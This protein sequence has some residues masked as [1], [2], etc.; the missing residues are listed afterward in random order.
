MKAHFTRR[1]VAGLIVVIPIGAVL[2]AVY[3]LLELLE[4]LG[5]P[6][7]GLIG[8]GTWVDAFAEQILIILS[9]VFVIYLLGYLADRPMFRKRVESLDRFLVSMIPGYS[10]IKAIIG[11]V[12]K[13]ESLVEELR[14]VL[15]QVQ[16]GDRIGFEIER[17]GSGQVVIYLPNTPT[18]VSGITL[19][20]EQSRV[21]RL[22]IPP[23]RVLEMLSFYGAGLVG[24]LEGSQKNGSEEKG[25]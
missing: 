15:V 23:H 3:S 25:R 4:W 13:E 19:G 14:P 9:G 2:F 18:A 7:F 1:L 5:Q 8:T 12:V 21:T 6:L 11:G 24:E 10:M 22:D 17:S 16:D 20:V